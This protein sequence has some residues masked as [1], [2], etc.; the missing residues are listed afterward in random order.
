MKISTLLSIAA[1]AAAWV[2]PH[3]AL[4]QVATYQEPYRPQF[5]FT[6]AINWMN[7]PNGLLDYQGEHHLFFQYNPFGTTWAPTISWGHAVSTDWVHWKELPVAIPATSTIGI[8]SGSAVV[9]KNNSSGFGAPGNP[10]LVP[11]TARPTLR[12]VPI[13]RTARS[14][15][16]VPRPRIS[17]S[18]RIGDEPGLRT[19][20]IQ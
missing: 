10:P 8:F 11:S 1:I 15:Q 12:P 4:A 6:P 18:A 9:D 5:H 20:I 3:P 17:P 14:F 16:R 7:D 13:Q 19:P 2:D